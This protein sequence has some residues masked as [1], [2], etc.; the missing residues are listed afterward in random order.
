MPDDEKMHQRTV[1]LWLAWPTR[2]ATPTPEGGACT[3]KT[4]IQSSAII[5]LSNLSRYF[6]QLCNSGRKWI[7]YKNHNRHTIPHPHGQA[8]GCPLWGVWRK[9]TH[10]N[11]T[12]LYL[13]ASSCLGT[14]NHNLKMSAKWRPFCLSL[15]VLNLKRGTS[16]VK[17]SGPLW[18][19]LASNVLEKTRLR[20]IESTMHCTEV[21][22]RKKRVWGACY[23][24]DKLHHQMFVYLLTMTTNY[25]FPWSLP[26]GDPNSHIQSIVSLL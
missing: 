10:Y 22:P 8:M 20:D 7:K 18:T 25:Q 13:G 17:L 11:G 26:S 15:N 24:W 19:S 1:S 2:H 9:L 23:I 3:C 21:M 14:W 5:S 12:P 4:A 6:I 16:Y